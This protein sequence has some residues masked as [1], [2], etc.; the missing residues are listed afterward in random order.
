MRQASETLAGRVAYLDM[1]PV[2]M[3]EAHSAGLPEHQLW[4]RGGF[5]D[6]LLAADDARSFDWRQDFIRSY[7]ERDV[8]MFAPRLPA[9]TLGR[10]W[11]MLAHQQGGQ[12]NQARLAASLGVS[13]P[14]VGR[15][16]DLLCDLHL[17]RR[18]TPWAANVG[19]RLVRTPKVYV[20]DSGLVHALLG[21][22]T[23]HDLLGHPVAGASYEGFALETLIQCAGHRYRA[24]FYRTHDGAEIDL[25]LERGGRAEMAIE[26][27]RSSAPSTERGFTEACEALGLTQRWVVYPGQERF[28]LRHGAQAIGLVELASQLAAGG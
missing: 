18:L 27:K 14:T 12:L 8:P 9:Q 3:T 22:G 24:H 13:E 16:I 25:V 15:Y 23:E 20:R 19:K 21:L 1:G 26:V 10:L 5:P 11:T 4:L 6:S 28:P 17:T 7:L 2:D